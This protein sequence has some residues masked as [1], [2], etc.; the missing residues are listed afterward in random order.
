MNEQTTSVVVVGAGPVGC[1]LALELARH[2]VRCTVV[3]RAPTTTPHPK[4][5]FL[6][7]RSMELLR[8]V[9]VAEAIR[10]RGVAARH[11][12]DFHW[13]DRLGAPPITVWQYQSVSGM[14]ERMRE[15]N[16]GSAPW[17]PYQRLQGSLLEELLRARVRDL[18]GVELHEGT[19]VTSLDQH[20]DGVEL[21]LVDG[22]GH[23]RSLRASYVVGC[24]GAGSV[25]RRSMGIE[26]PSLAP[27]AP[28]RDVYF[29]SADPRL[30]AHGRFFLGIAARGLV[31]VSRDEQD[32]WT[33]SFPRAGNASDNTD[34]VAEIRSRIGADLDVDEVINVVDWEGTLAVAERYRRD[35]VF[36]AGDAAHQFF[37]TGGHGANTGI[38][39]AVDLGWKLAAVVAGWGGARLLDSYEIE[40][41]PVALFNREMSANLLEVWRRYFTL[42]DN[43]ASPEHIAGY[44]EQQSFQIDNVGLHFGY[45]YDSAVVHA[46][47]GT[48]PRWR[49]RGIVPTT[50]PGCRPPS[51]RLADGAELF[52]LLSAAFTLVD[53]S[54]DGV[55]EPL[56]DEAVRAGVPMAHLPCA[57]VHA[58]KVWE[59]DLVLVRPDQHVAWRAD[60][61]PDDWDGV[62]RRVTGR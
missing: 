54:D 53:F 48:P 18:P 34:P 22:Q 37:P 16:D 41:R 21:E 39:D 58:R 28:Q 55:G 23:S 52:D 25:V 10:D 56:V 47:P 61:A 36:L 30:R 35:R 1:T 57:D 13:I 31:L 60:Q 4:M 50:W 42:F 8:R 11:P 40:R 49:W 45:R 59:R 6:N 19:R 46:E 5:D 20:A 32:T 2:N 43:G 29:R 44:L 9:G 38:G 26:S 15:D 14:R 51:V 12:F 62:L 17:E 24:D 3:E 7:A 27:P 33:A